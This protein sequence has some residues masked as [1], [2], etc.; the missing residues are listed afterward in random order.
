MLVQPMA[1]DEIDAELNV[2]RIAAL[3]I[4]ISAMSKP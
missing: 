1:G 3:P 2:S 4:L